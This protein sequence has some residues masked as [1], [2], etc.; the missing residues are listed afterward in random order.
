MAYAGPAGAPSASL[1][2]E[3]P[4]LVCTWLARHACAA[5]AR[6]VPRAIALEQVHLAL[7]L[8]VAVAVAVVVVRELLAAA[9]RGA[10]RRAVVERERSAVRGHVSAEARALLGGRIVA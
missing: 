3:Y 5:A 1:S 10:A 2:D 7:A 6:R 4:L 8:A 9:A